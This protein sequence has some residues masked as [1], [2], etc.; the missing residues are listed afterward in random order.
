MTGKTIFFLL[1][2]L[3]AFST[4]AADISQDNFISRFAKPYRTQVCQDKGVMRRCFKVTQQ[5][6]EQGIDKAMVFCRKR[7]AKQMPD[8]IKTLNDSRYWGSQLA[9]CIS[10]RFKKHHKDAFQVKNLKCKGLR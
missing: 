7:L 2:T 10:H 8:N 4:G 9:L 1:L 6:C 5:G 3:P